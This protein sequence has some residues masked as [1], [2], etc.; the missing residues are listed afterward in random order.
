MCKN[1]AMSHVVAVLALSEVIGYDMTIPPMIFDAAGKHYD[2]RLCSLD[3][4][5][6]QAYGGYRLLLDHGPEVLAEADTVI[7]PGTRMRGPRYE[8]TLPGE[9]AEAL[10]TIRPGT[11]M[12]SICTG[13]FVLA[14]AG[15]LDG[16]RA[17]THWQHSQ[18]F[19]ELYPKVQLNEDVLFVDDG[20]V[21]TSAGLAAGIDL[22]L[23][24]LRNDHGSEVANHA[25]RYCVVPSW[26]DGG[27]RQFIERP[28]P[29]I[30]EASTAATRS[31]ALERLSESL[32]LDTLAGHARMSVRT[33][34]RR[35]RAETGMS[36]GK[37]LLRQRLEHARHLLESTDLAIDRVAAESG[38]GTAASLRQHLRVNLGVSPLGYRKAFRAPS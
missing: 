11:R 24:V 17:T 38:L 35:F 33:F 7:I 21:L 6:V 28:L 12:M 37:W 4:K 10:A 30:G 20:D 9:L 31:W 27:Q 3:G 15:F 36:P 2:V 34:S 25:A 29:E 5:P 1:L 16:R 13:A 22:C 23:H 19:R 18:T 26:R 14:A 32:D 8:G